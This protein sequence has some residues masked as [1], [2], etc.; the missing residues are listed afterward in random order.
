MK[1]CVIC[2]EEFHPRNYRVKCCSKP[3]SYQNKKNS[4]KSTVNVL[5]QRNR[6]LKQRNSFK[7]KTGLTITKSLTRPYV[8]KEDWLFANPLVL[9][10]LLI[11]QKSIRLIRKQKN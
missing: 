10:S 7:E 8:G 5:K 9:E 1:T 11:I 6:V 2:G 3:C 4:K